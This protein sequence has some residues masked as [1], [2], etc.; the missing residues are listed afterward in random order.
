MKKGVLLINLGT[1]KTPTPKDVFNY[2]NEFLT[3]KRVID[4]PFLKRHLLVRGV[5]VPSRFRSSAASYETIWKKEGSPLLLYAKE[6]QRLLQKILGEEYCVEVAMRYQSPSIEEA[7]KSLERLSLSELIIIPLFPQYASATTG[8]ICEKVFAHLAQWAVMPKIRMINYFFD[9]PLLI[10][11]F[12]SSAKKMHY[13]T[14][15]HILMSFHGLPQSH[16]KK[17]D[18]SNF[19]QKQKDCCH[20]FCEKNASCYGAQCYQTAH[21]I[22]QKL[23]LKKEDFTVCFQSRLGKNPWI[24]PYTSSVLQSL[25]KLGKKKILV[26]CPA[27]VCDCLETLHEIAIEY[28]KEFLHLG[29]EKLDLAPGLNSEPL[30]IETLKSLVEGQHDFTS[31]K[32]K[33]TNELLASTL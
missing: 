27:F 12:S 23:S 17:A 32:T 10:E 22:A 3:D 7:L 24:E 30:W 26:L 6:N 33:K 29:G 20:H 14:Y 11:A 13:E 21:L 16:L 15:D 18:K 5:I 8:S 4:L 25:I 2:L 31:F 19:C 1:P 28:Q 9:H